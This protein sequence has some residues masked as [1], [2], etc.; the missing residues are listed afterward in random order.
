MDSLQSVGEGTEMGGTF[1]IQYNG[2]SSSVSCGWQWSPSELPNLKKHDSSN[3]WWQKRAPL[4]PAGAQN[5]HWYTNT[6]KEGKV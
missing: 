3:S 6:M 4:K 1:T 2:P 5:S